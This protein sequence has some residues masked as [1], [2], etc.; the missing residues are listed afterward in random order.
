MPEEHTAPQVNTHGR[1]RVVISPVLNGVA[2]ETP[3]RE[4]VRCTTRPECAGCSYPAH[5]FICHFSGGNCLRYQ[6][7]A[8]EGDD[9]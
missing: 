1:S 5:G 3:G 4:P 2:R 9:L 6:E 8:A 7:P